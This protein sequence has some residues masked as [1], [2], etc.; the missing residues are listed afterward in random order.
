MLCSQAQWLVD[1]IL[2][3]FFMSHPQILFESCQFA[4]MSGWGFI[5]CDSS[6]SVGILKTVM[7]CGTLMP[8]PLV[9]TGT[10]DLYCLSTFCH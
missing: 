1:S 7:H 2:A 3:D 9:S 6:H 8:N 4:H 10:V 5:Y